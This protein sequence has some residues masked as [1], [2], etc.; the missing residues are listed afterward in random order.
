MFCCKIREIHNEQRKINTKKSRNSGKTY[1]IRFRFLATVILAMLAITVFI[2]GLSIYEVDT[3]IQDQSENFVSISCDNEGDRINNSFKSME[4]SVEI[5]KSY[6][7]E[8]FNNETDVEDRVFQKQVINRAEQMFV[9]VARHT[10]TANSI[11]YYF[12]LDPSIS[13]SKAGLFYS[14]LDGGNEFISLEPTDLSLYSKDDIE[15]VGWF[16][17]PYEAQKPIWMK[18]YYNLKLF[19]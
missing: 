8:F 14:K 18:P 5:M 6:L 12:R 15:R 7:M 1:S 17:Q 11:S 13:D 16:W 2:G 4:K 3:Y 10:S 9:D 19:L